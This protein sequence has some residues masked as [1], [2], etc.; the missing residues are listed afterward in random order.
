M[1][2]CIFSDIHGNNYAF[3]SFVN[4]VKD[5]F[6]YYLFA[7]DIYGYYYGIDEIL[8]LMNSLNPLKMVIGNHDANY[9]KIHNDYKDNLY[10]SQYGLSY[11][12]R[13]DKLY[14]LLIKQPKHIEIELDDI[15]IKMVHGTLND[16]LNGR[17][18]PNKEYDYCS[19]YL[20]YDVVIQG[21]THYKMRKNF[22]ETMIV[23]PGSIGQSRNLDGLTYAVLD[24][25]SKEVTFKKIN[26]N[27]ELLY[28][29]INS[30]E[31]ANIKLIEVLER[32]KK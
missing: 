3:R 15:K 14:N 5:K 19:D 7:G 31:P 4:E 22:F 28:K 12:I 9:I 1:K 6:D 13:S 2:I 32:E 11:N 10:S 8:S 27:K 21:H 16:Y 26:W 23:N 30:I 17:D 25:Q 24:T 29:E 18:Y 20:N